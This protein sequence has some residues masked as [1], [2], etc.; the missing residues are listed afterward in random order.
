MGERNVR[1]SLTRERWVRP[2]P[3]IGWRMPGTA[4]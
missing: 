1:S 4:A 2:R 3:T